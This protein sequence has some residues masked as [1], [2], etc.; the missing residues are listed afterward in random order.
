[1]ILQTGMR[2]DIPAFYSQWFANRLNEG[3]VLTRNPYNPMQVTRYNLDPTVVDLI[4][5][6]SKNPGPMLNYMDLLASYR[7]TYWFV[8]ITAYER[9]FE[10]NVPEIDK[11]IRDFQEI[12]RIVGIDSMGWRYDPIFLN[13]EYTVERHLETY[14][15]IASA[16]E[17]YTK[18]SVI[19]FTDLYQ[20][21]RKN[22]PEA[23]TVGKADRLRLGSE[24]VQI[25]KKHGMTVK[26]CGEGDELSQFG[27]DCRGC[28]TPD[29]YEKVLGLTMD[30][31][32]KKPLR[33]ECA[34]SLGNDIGAY[35]TCPHL[36]R[37]CY[38]NYDEETVRRNFKLHDPKSPFLSG[39]SQPG[40]KVHQAEQKSFVNGQMTLDMFL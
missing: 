8:T 2:T 28:M 10:P 9:D 19:S 21:V 13:D 39:S 34:C 29:V 5:F 4:A 12:S 7:G 1:M 25:A 35:N 24:M 40:D 18:T 27:A 26:P 14:A 33:Q 15:Y 30:F 6:C 31:P 17:G 20:K 23:R 32:K 11:V 16:L 22:F 36:C 37:Y 3:Y 38:A